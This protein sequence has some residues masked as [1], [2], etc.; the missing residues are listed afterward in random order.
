MSLNL[1]ARHATL[2]ALI[3]ILFSACDRVIVKVPD[4]STLC[5]IQSISGPAGFPADSLSF[6]YNQFGNPDHVIRQQTS[7]AVPNYFFKYDKDHRL[8][9][10]I[11]VYPP[12]FF[13]GIGFDNW[14]RLHYK[15]GRI[16]SDSVYEFG[17]ELGGNPGPDPQT[18]RTLIRQTSFYQ[19]DAQGRM[20]QSTDISP[21]NYTQ[22]N[23]YTYGRDGN[24]SK[25]SFTIA[26]PPFQPT[27]TAPTFNFYTGYDN[28]I[29]PNRTNPIWQ[30]LDRDYS[31]NNIFIA[32]S[33]DEIGLPLSI[34]FD[35]FH[36]MSGIPGSGAT[37]QIP[38]IFFGGFLPVN[39]QYSCQYNGKEYK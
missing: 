30:F 26:Q 4:E 2:L 17:N 25:T 35:D 3:I 10:I 33:Y 21:S 28:K 19:F 12:E 14:H 9:D 5:S 15:N 16:F 6:F 34:T 31:M 27:P 23:T 38:F 29:N 20:I 18:Q 36:G 39:V 8:T 22:V 37:L 1:H 24:L 11:G 13:P 7:T 32:N